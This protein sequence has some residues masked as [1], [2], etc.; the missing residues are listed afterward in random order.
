MS[1]VA[2]GESTLQHTLQSLDITQWIRDTISIDQ[3]SYPLVPVL[4]SRT[5]AFSKLR[6]EVRRRDPRPPYYTVAFH[7]VEDRGSFPRVQLQIDRYIGGI[8]RKGFS[9]S[10]GSILCLVEDLWLG[11]V[12]C[13]E[14]GAPTKRVCTS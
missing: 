11:G 4:Q 3:G 2:L 14:E 8:W 7:K 13:F 10:A 5:I 1:V 12:K 9:C 6:R